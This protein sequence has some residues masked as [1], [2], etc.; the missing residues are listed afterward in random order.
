MRVVTIDG[1]FDGSNPT[2]KLGYKPDQQLLGVTLQ[3]L[4]VTLCFLSQGGEGASPT[5]GTARR[6][7][8]TVDTDITRIFH[9]I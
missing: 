3:T 5:R 8:G 6:H 2:Y 7:G 1:W 4:G 9:N